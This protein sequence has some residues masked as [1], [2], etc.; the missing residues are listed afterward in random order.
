MT[1]SLRRPLVGTLTLYTELVA[2]RA[3]MAAEA[4][5]RRWAGGS[6]FAGQ[7]EEGESLSLPISDYSP[8][9]P[10]CKPHL[11]MQHRRPSNAEVW[12]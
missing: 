2:T 7:E 1:R 6:P 8:P 5:W 9:G 10:C 12:P 4:C 3:W 11:V